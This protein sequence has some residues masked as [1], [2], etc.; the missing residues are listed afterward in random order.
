MFHSSNHFYKI[1]IV[2]INHNNVSFCGT[3]TGFFNKN[4]F[5]FLKKIVIFE[6]Y[7]LTPTKTGHRIFGQVISKM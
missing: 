4:S 1:L 3:K 7:S 6:M 5:T 2:A